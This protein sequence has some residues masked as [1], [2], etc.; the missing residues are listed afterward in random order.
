MLFCAAQMCVD[1]DNTRTAV[2]A[3]RLSPEETSALSVSAKDLLICIKWLNNWT[4]VTH[5]SN[6]ELTRST[7]DHHWSKNGVRSQRLLIAPPY[8]PVFLHGSGLKPCPVLHITSLH[9]SIT[10][11]TP[12]PQSAPHREIRF[13]GLYWFCRDGNVLWWCFFLQ[14]WIERCGSQE[15]RGGLCAGV[16]RWLTAWLFILFRSWKWGSVGSPSASLQSE[17]FYSPD[18]QRGEGAGLNW[19]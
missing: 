14:V 10:S 6:W 18:G 7:S 8:P 15:G 2:L 11:P 12:W 16:V 1:H 3:G 9:A 5:T 19:P 13:V 4:P 17:T